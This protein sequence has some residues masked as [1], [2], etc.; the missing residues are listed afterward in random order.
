MAWTWNAATISIRDEQT[1][2][3][4]GQ[5]LQ[6]AALLNLNT[7]QVSKMCLSDDEDLFTLGLPISTVQILS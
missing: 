7:E 2:L 3:A 6:I 5:K 1:K 4:F